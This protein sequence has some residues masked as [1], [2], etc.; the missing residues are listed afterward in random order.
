MITSYMKHNVMN[1]TIKY[2]Y[3]T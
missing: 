1:K 2:Y 3:Y